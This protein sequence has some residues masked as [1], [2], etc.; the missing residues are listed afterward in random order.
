MSIAKRKIGFYS[1]S[2]TQIAD[3]KREIIN[4]II[5][6]DIINHIMSLDKKDRVNDI[7]K[8]YKFHLLDYA[9]E[10]AMV[11]QLFFKSSKYHHRPPLI[12][13]DTTEERD[14][15][16]KLSE[17]ESEKTHAVLKY[18]DDEV[19]LVKED[20]MHGMSIKN[21]VYYFNKFLWQMRHDADNP[22]NYVV[23]F[24]IIPNDDFLQELNN[25]S[26]VIIGEVYIDRQILGSDFLNIASRTEEIQSLIQLNIKAQKKKSIKDAA[27]EIYYKFTAESSLIKKIRI[28]GLNNIGERILLDSDLLKKMGYVSADLDE[29]TGIV[30]S[31]QIL[32]SLTSII[33]GF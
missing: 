31:E 13:K 15:P 5:I 11:Q 18:F 9:S 7:S 14:N 6:R 22:I 3:N 27:L 21:I 28:F 12:D 29:S 17:G 19:I 32:E 16:K 24:S 25:L 10:V 8:N 1:L 30:N 23:D 2:V 20:R 33:S 4:P 26:R